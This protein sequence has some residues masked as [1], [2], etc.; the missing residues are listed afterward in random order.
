[1]KTNE[2]RYT[3]WVEGTTYS[4]T[5]KANS[6]GWHKGLI[7]EARKD[8]YTGLYIYDR[9]KDDFV[10]WKEYGSSRPATDKLKEW[11]VA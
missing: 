1:M 11:C 3:I 6:L 5:F 10:V 2:P 8:Y 4:Q 7:D 9:V